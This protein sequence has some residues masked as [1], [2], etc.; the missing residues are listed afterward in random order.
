MKILILDDNRE[1]CENVRDILELHGYQVMTAYTVESALQMAKEELPELALMDMMI[2]GSEALTTL[3]G[4]KQAAPGVTVLVVTAL[5]NV[6]LVS[7]VLQAK[8][9]GY[10]RK[11]LD[12][13]RLLAFIN[14]NFPQP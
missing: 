10:F 9:S 5:E 6:G 11:P 8:A 14:S 2:P 12:V 1:F 7:D 3:A 4:L 13:H